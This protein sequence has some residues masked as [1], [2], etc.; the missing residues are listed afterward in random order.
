MYDTAHA[1]I[2]HMAEK[3]L[4]H[5]PEHQWEAE[6]HQLLSPPLDVRDW[7]ASSAALVA[8]PESHVLHQLDCA[9]DCEFVVTVAYID[10]ALLQPVEPLHLTIH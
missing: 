6:V 2:A 10:S 1:D 8:P 4:A 3:V 5:A 9:V 7:S